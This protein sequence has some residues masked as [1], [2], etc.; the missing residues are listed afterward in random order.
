MDGTGARL[1]YQYSA[2]RV[3]IKSGMEQGDSG[4]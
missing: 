4:S 3:Q 1:A 2:A